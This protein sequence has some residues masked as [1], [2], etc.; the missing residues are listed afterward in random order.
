MQQQQLMD[1]NVYGS[2][3]VKELGAVLVDVDRYL[4]ALKMCV[5]NI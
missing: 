1:Q 3:S 5:G 4:Q 2:K